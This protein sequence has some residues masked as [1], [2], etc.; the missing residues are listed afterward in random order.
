MTA[1]N[2]TRRLPAILGLTA[3]AVFGGLIV[4]TFQRVH[5]TG[6][7]VSRLES[8]VD[9]LRS[10]FGATSGATVSPLLV[11][12]HLDVPGRGEVFPAMTTSGAPEYWP[13]A[14]LRIT[15]TADRAIMQIV[16]VEIPG[17]SRRRE[18]TVIIGAHEER[19]LE[20]EPELLP[21][22]YA[23]EEIRSASM[24][25][26]AR[27]LNG[28]VLFSK[29]RPVLIHPGSD[30][31]WGRQFANA[32]VA[33]RWVTPHDPAILD[34]VSQ[35]REF[36]PEGRLAGYSVSTGSPGEISRH[37]R[38]Q[39]MAIY[40]ALQ[41]SGIS[42]VNSLFVMGDYF[43]EAQRVRLPAETLRLR[44]ANCMDITVAF[45]SA[46]ENLDM[47]PL[48][49][50]LPGHAVAGVRLGPNSDEVLYLDLT[51]LPERSFGDAIRSAEQV[52]SSTPDEK[53]LVVDVAAARVLGLY[54]LVPEQPSGTVSSFSGGR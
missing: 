36:I 9:T 40:Q 8:Q 41:K 4:L 30:I 18:E 22:A 10:G 2:I 54:P 33:A 47:Q 34:L 43:G 16:T 42:Y 39:A 28:Q 31:Y 52:L 21:R 13:L 7:R 37:V 35:A 26:R 50:I 17:W 53:T 29:N 19:Q 46:V 23:N 45:A 32:Q 24:D 14:I 6:S 25:V 15:N 12:Y 1:R 51:V 38:L 11:E 49:V 5:E 48:L 3:I 27:S 20:L 44:S